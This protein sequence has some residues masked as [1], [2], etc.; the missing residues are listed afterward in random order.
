MTMSVVVFILSSINWLIDWLIDWTHM[1]RCYLHPAQVTFPPL[2]QPVKVGTQFSDP[3]RMR[4]RVR[5]VDLDTYRGGM[6]TQRR[7]PIPELTGLKVELLRSHDKRRYRYAKPPV[8]VSD[9]QLYGSIAWRSVVAVS[10]TMTM[11]IYRQ[12]LVQSFW[13]RDSLLIYFI[14]TKS[15]LASHIHVYRL[16][17]YIQ[18]TRTLN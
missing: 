15:F 18:T 1:P 11:F 16:H 8:F 7:S 14:S 4:G 3:K 2:L 12:T 6:P 17:F 10:T 13:L 5:W 9:L